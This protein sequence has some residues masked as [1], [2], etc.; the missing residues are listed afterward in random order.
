MRGSDVAY[1]EFEPDK[2]EP[3]FCEE[4]LDLREC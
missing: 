1:R 2:V 3:E 4:R